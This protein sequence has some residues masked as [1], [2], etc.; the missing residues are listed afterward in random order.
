MSRDTI[1]LSLRQALCSQETA[2]VV[3]ALITITSDDLADPI[4]LSLDAKETVSRGNTYLP[5]PCNLTLPLD[6]EGRPTEAK[7]QMDILDQELAEEVMALETSPDFLLEIVL[8]STPDTVEIAWA[9]F[10]LSDVSD[11]ALVMEGTLT[12]QQYFQQAYPSW[13]FTPVEFPGLFQWS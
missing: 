4:Y 7:F 1:S 8:A 9:G 5:V 12:V 13:T 2:E 11:D 6:A 3:I 10:Q